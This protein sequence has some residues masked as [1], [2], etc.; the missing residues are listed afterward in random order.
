M[1]SYIWPPDAGGSATV[2]SVALADASTIP[3]YTVSG[4]P[5][6]TNGTLTLTL[7]TEVKNK[8][9]AGPTTGADAQPTFRSLILA[10][11][12]AMADQT[13]LGNISGGSAVPVALT[14]TQATT[15]FNVFSSSLKGLV[16]NS[17]G[18]TANFLRADGSFAVPAGTGVT[19][20][21]LTDSTSTF[22]ITG[23]PVTGSG[24]LTLSAFASQSQNRFLGGPSGSS[25]AATF[26]LLVGA[27][28][29]NP[30]SSSLGGVQSAAAVSNQWINSISTSGVPALSQPAFTNISG[31]LAASSGGTGVANNA[32]STL[33]ISG[34]F[35]TTLTVSNTTGVTLPTTGTLA[36]RAG[37]ETFTNKTLTTPIVNG[38]Q[39][40]TLV[41]SSAY[42]MVATDFTVL[43]SGTTTITLPSASAAGTLNNVYCIK[44]TDTNV[45]TI[46][47]TSSQLI[48]GAAKITLSR[49]FHAV[50]LQ[51]DGTNWQVVNKYGKQCVVGTA[52]TTDS[53]ITSATYVG[54]S[55]SPDVT[56]IAATSGVYLI[57][58][59]VTLE[60]AS[61]GDRWQT[62]IA[63]TGAGTPVNIFSGETDGQP[64]VDSETQVYTYLLVTLS[65]NTSYTFQFQARR[66]GGTLNLRNTN[67]AT[68]TVL[69]AQEL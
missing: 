51:S 5:V 39:M 8:V 17:G 57:F 33:T 7:S 20:V 10:D 54:F 48:D 12:P 32:S 27:D 38:V 43:A 50:W 13:I 63:S 45:I 65:S 53:S 40:P 24:T 64:L 16:P 4:S 47:T 9:F 44:N 30:S 2:T 69:V 49:K 59:T 36:T 21:A 68:G 19:S 6:T 1:A 35:A 18:G 60:N 61:I 62:R 11:F 55:T 66:S 67:V 46:D 29:P 22:T 52:Q 28:L 37:T 56:F 34:N 23:S 25:G 58:G 14:A 15:V 42:T 41:K 26:R 31:V 3:I